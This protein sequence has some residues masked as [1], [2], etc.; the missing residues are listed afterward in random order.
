LRRWLK[1]RVLLG[2]ARFPQTELPVIRSSV[3]GPAAPPTYRRRNVGATYPAGSRRHRTRR[4]CE[5]RSTSPHRQNGAHRRLVTRAAK[6][7]NAFGTRSLGCT[8]PEHR[9]RAIESFLELPRGVSMAAH[10]PRRTVLQ[11]PHVPASSARSLRPPRSPTRSSSPPSPGRR[12]QADREAPH[13][14]RGGRVRRPV[15]GDVV[16]RRLRIRRDDPGPPR[17][18]R[19]MRRLEPPRGSQRVAD[20]PARWRE[21]AHSTVSRLSQVSAPLL[22]AWFSDVWATSGPLQGDVPWSCDRVGTRL[23]EPPP[24]RGVPPRLT[25][26]RA[27]LARVPDDGR[28]RAEEVVVFCPEC[29]EREFGGRRP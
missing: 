29:D 21:V 3:S 10:P 4:S 14:A 6:P 12:R 19:R 25:R 20:G 28:G 13:L 16:D 26:E 18:E 9:N 17:R 11:A 27:W 7:Q 1:P 8:G 5:L 22:Q 23:H 15:R 2:S 24:V